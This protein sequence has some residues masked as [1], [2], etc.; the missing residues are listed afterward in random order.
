MADRT[1]LL[2]AASE[3]VAVATKADNSDAVATKAG[4]SGKS[5][6]I[7]HIMISA[8]AAPGG[9]VSVT[10][11][12]DAGSPATYERIELPAA[13]FAPVSVNYVRPIRIPKGLDAV[14]T[15][16]A[17]GGTTRGTITMKGFTMVEG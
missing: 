4:E 1:R 10:L 9:V 6:Y 14:L 17:I 3:W 7:T 8:S 13:A 15:L 16:P 12:D 2:T 11:V 5:H